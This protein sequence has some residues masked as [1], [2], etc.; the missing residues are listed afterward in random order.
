MQTKATASWSSGKRILEWQTRGRPDKLMARLGRTS[1]HGHG[2]IAE[3]LLT[4]FK[5]ILPFVG[6]ARPER[7]KGKDT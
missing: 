3:K 6:Q 4:S 1:T 5:K 7:K 2:L